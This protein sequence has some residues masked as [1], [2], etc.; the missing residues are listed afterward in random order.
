MSQPFAELPTV[1]QAEK[2]FTVAFP[3]SNIR[4]RLHIPEQL[5]TLHVLLGIDP[6]LLAAIDGQGL[7]DR[8][9]HFKVAVGEPQASPAVVWSRS[10]S[11]RTLGKGWSPAAIDLARWANKDVTVV[12][13]IDAD[14]GLDRLPTGWGDVLFMT[15]EAAALAQDIPEAR[16]LD[17]WRAA[18][19]GAGGML[20]EGDA[21]LRAADIGSAVRWYGRAEQVEPINRPDIVFR[22]AVANSLAHSPA[23]DGLIQ[24]VR[25][26]DREFNIGKMGATL[27][28]EGHDFRWLFSAGNDTISGVPMNYG[29]ADAK[30]GYMWWIGDGLALLSNDR[31]RRVVVR[32]KVRRSTPPPVDMAIGIDGEQTRRVSITAGDN[33]WETIEVP[34]VLSKGYHSINIWY[35]NADT[36]NGVKRDAVVDYVTVDEV[37]Q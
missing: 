29:K 10:V 31:E 32:A 15:P 7:E 26:H 33:L 4:V 18:G 35:F 27:K 9:V 14:S 30:E 37:T 13:S 1:T 11:W 5:T 21:A 3:G 17:A 25:A 2:P 34:A 23:A 8:N 22:V 20:A 16:R 24:R 6:T 19:L 12:W 28:I 36:V